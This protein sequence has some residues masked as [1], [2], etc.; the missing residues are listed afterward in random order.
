MLDKWLNPIQNFERLLDDAYV[1]G[2]K[3]ARDEC[4][5][6]LDR[7]IVQ[8]SEVNSSVARQAREEI[9]GLGKHG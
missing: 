3:Q 6:I 7:L 2:A 8:Y 1:C 9:A 4:L 5:D